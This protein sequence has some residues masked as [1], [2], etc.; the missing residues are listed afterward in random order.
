MHEVGANIGYIISQKGIQKGAQNYLQN[1]NIKSMTYAEF[2]RHYLNKW[3]EQ[4]FCSTI[5]H[6]SDAQG[7]SEF[8]IGQH[9]LG[10][11]DFLNQRFPLS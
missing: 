3:I 7:Q 2:Q 9:F 10:N 11:D 4:Q 1:T 6:V 8:S 5:L